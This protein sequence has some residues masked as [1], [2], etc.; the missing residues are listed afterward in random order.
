[1]A[2]PDTSQLKLALDSAHLVALLLPRSPSYDAV[3]SALALKL[4]LEQT[5]KTVTIAC[6][7]PMTVEFNRLVGVDSITTSFGSRNFVISFPGQ[8]EVV[9]K[10]SYNIEAGELQLVITPKPGTIGIDHR[11][12][13]FTSAGIQ[14]EMVIMVG[15]DQ[16][17]DL[18]QIYTDIKDFLATTKVVSL[19]HAQP[20]ERYAGVQINDIS[21]SS[22]CELTTVL[23]ESLGLNLTTDSAT[24]LLTGLET[25]TNHFQSNLVSASTFEA[26]ANL[27]RFG[28]KRQDV[29]SS[30]NLPTGSIPQAAQ[31]VPSN[32]QGFGTDSQ[33]VT[34]APDWYEPKVFRGTNLS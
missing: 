29:F 31:V 28:G 26:A 2:K 12:L 30:A 22:L 15:V 27:Y 6:P 7:E 34:P 23:H 20:L 25:S 11:Q 1:M 18:G 10:V 14:A 4:S 3:A 16:L 8:T 9:D 32:I 17:S 19:T 33:P 13:K 21:S 24:N 5:G